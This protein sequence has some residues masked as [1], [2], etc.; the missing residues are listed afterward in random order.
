MYLYIYLYY[1]VVINLLNTGTYFPCHWIFVVLLNEWHNI[2]TCKEINYLLTLESRINMYITISRIN[3]YLAEV[4]L[5]AGNE[6]TPVAILINLSLHT[7]VILQYM[8]FTCYLYYI[9]SS[10]A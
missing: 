8:K 4:S 3:M 1:T 5:E 6:Q 10:A 2:P 9:R 7:F